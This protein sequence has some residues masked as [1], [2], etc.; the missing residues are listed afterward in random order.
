M[1]KHLF[2]KKNKTTSHEE[3]ELTEAE[4]S[5]K[6]PI[7]SFDDL[8]EQ[9][10]ALA[11]EKQLNFAELIGSYSWEFDMTKGEIT[12]GKQLTF[13]VQIIGSVSFNDNS[14]M[15]AWANT[16]SGMPDHL[17]VQAH[18]LKKLGDQL[19]ISEL[20][21]G[22][23]GTDS[24]F[25]HIMGMVAC[26]HFN[27]DGYYCANYG[28][29]TLV[30]TL[31]SDK[32]PQVDKKALEKALTTFPQL[33]SAVDI[34]HKEAFK[35]YLIDRKCKILMTDSEIKGR[36]GDKVITASFDQID[37]LVNLDGKV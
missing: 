22:H 1:F 29:G 19:N 10:A 33:I 14:W 7:Q 2:K 4:I 15:W 9:T 27:T 36:Y 30:V 5:H 35:N 18:E 34:N 23:F 24:G 37:R 8:F 3:A 21:D 13:P 12:F 17:L 6:T 26:G 32:I 31:Q 28:Q 20:S 11:F 16:Q 25:E